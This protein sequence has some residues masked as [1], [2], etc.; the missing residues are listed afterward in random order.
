MILSEFRALRPGDK[1]INKSAKKE[2][3]VKK[4]TVINSRCEIVFQEDPHCL[5][6]IRKINMPNWMAAKKE[7]NNGNHT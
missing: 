2:L 7:K 1:L 6:T 5:Y 4:A 3:T